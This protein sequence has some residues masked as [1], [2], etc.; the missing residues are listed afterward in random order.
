[1]ENDKNTYVIS[2]GG[3]IIVPDMIDVAF[4][5]QFKEF[6]LKHVKLGQRFVLITGGGKTCRRY[7]AALCEV[8][9]SASSDALDWV[10]IWTTQ[11]NAQLVR[12]M[13][14]DD[15]D[16]ISGFDPHDPIKSEKNIIVGAGYEPGCSSDYDTVA[17]AENI[18]AKYIINLSNI[19]YVYDK[20][21]RKYS[22]AVKI[23]EISWEDFIALLPDKWDPGLNSPFDPIAARKAKELGIS[24]AMINGR[25]LDQLEKCLLHEKFDGTLIK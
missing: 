18:G 24:V 23:E 8:N 11:V 4:L 19:D 7:Q 14:G 9:S 3:S 22:D 13:F 20:D 21:P 16:L 10:G 1:M 15:A 25:K 17:I 6:I 5:K 2:L 12:H